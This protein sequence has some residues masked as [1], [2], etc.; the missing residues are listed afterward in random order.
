MA[1]MKNGYKMSQILLMKETKK[2]LLLMMMMTYDEIEMNDCIFTVHTISKL[3][4]EI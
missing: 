3:N 4:E 1:G 2:L